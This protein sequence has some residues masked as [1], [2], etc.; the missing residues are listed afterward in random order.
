MRAGRAG[1]H[2]RSGGREDAAL[3]DNREDALDAAPVLPV[4]AEPDRATFARR[5]HHDMH[6]RRLGGGIHNWRPRVASRG[7]SYLATDQGDER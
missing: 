5:E 2:R 7:M 1:R 4:A 6:G 3:E